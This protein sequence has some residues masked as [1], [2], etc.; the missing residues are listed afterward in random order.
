MRGREEGERQPGG[1]KGRGHGAVVADQA[2]PMD[3]LSQ[4]QRW[5]ARF[6]WSAT[7]PWIARVV[8]RRRLL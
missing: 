8:N 7:L 2:G 3:R 5:K 1:G 4:M 6:L